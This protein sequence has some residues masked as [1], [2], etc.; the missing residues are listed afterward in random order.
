MYDNIENIDRRGNSYFAKNVHAAGKAVAQE[1]LD[2][3]ERVVVFDRNF[4]AE[5]YTGARSV[6]YEIVKD[7]SQTD[8]FRLEILRV[9]ESGENAN[10]STEVM[11]AVVG[12]IRR[13]VPAPH[14]G[15]AFGSHGKGWLQRAYSGNVSRSGNTDG[16]MS[17]A[18]FADLWSE[19]ENSLTRYFQGYGE[20]LDVSEFRDALDDWAWDFILLD[21][22]FMA[23]AE[24]L[25]EM[26][27]L[28]DY[29][30]A[31]PTEIMAAGFPYDMVVS[32]LFQEWENN[33]ENSVVDVADAF[34]EAYRSGTM[35]SGYPHATVAV[36]KTSELDALAESVKRLNLRLNEVTGVGGIQ[37]YERF[38][39]PGHVFFDLDDYISRIRASV[40]PTEYNEFKAQLDRTV[41]FKDHT[42][43]FFSAAQLN[44]GTVKVEHYSGLN[45][46]IPWSQTARLV[47]WYQQTEWYKYVYG[48]N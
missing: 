34:V 31:S 36:V 22:C 13:V 10:L 12:D 18:P 48:G 43:Y 15:L 33:L 46:F 47:N 30:I 5:G 41:V 45:V 25:Y 2:P 9:Y 32:I 16:D 4:K 24:A 26:R 19:R 37:Y 21:D 3:D 39:T 14:Y 11:A 27:S 8:G 29:F 1:V 20:K 42:E 23:S 7:A 38:T 40:T 44:N 6:V 28:T 35:E 17:Q